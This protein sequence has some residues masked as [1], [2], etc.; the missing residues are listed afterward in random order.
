MYSSGDILLFAL[1]AQRQVHWRSFKKYFDEVQRTS[2]ATGILEPGGNATAHRWQALRTLSCLGHIDIRFSPEGIL[3][4]AAP[5]TL[6]TLPG[7]RSSR[8]I[9]CGAR[10]QTTVRKLE[11]AATKLGVETTVCS[12]SEASPYAPTRVELH[13][14]NASLIH[15][16]AESTALRYLEVPP[17]RLLAQI[18]VSLQEYCQGLEWSEEPELNWRR[19]DFHTGNL[20]FLAGEVSQQRRLSRYQDP[21]TSIWRIR[22][23]Q[24]GK[25]AEIDPDWGRYAVLSQVSP[26]VLQYD[27]EN[28][29]AL[30][31]YGVPLPTL[32][33]RSF[34]LCGGYGPELKQITRLGGASSSR[35][36]VMYRDV[37]PSI[38]NSVANKVEQ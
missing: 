28:R 14:E 32:L 24:N 7:I 26:R 2:I 25:S 34:G 6:A 13:S 37:P 8:A 22:L 12:Q 29:E 10:S 16:I 31:P 23:W 1:S 3:I 5:P 38:F 17:A 18:S 35:R 20:Q 21:S 36:Y 33:A 19:E 27:R 9:L 15:A 30:V 4:A 11:Q